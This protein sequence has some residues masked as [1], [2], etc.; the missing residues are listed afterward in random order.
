MCPHGLDDKTAAD[1]DADVTVMPN[2]QAGD[3]RDRVDL[4]GLGSVMIHLVGRDIRHSVGRVDKGQVLRIQ[5]AIALD[6]TNTVGG[7]SADPVGPN[8]IFVAGQGIRVL[9]QLALER[10]FCQ[11]AAERL[12]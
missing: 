9:L 10:A 4:T 8:E 1:V 11:D 12:R 5:P 3:L 6:E 7:S 2:G